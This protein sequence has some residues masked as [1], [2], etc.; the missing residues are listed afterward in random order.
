LIGGLSHC[1]YI[2]REVAKA[3][4]LRSDLEYEQDR[5]LFPRG[6]GGQ[7]APFGRNPTDRRR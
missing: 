5:S 4:A 2:G 6:Q 3:E 1:A 7:W